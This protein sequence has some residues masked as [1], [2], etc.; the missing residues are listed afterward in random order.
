MLSLLENS[1]ILQEEIQLTEAQKEQIQTIHE[2]ANERRR[3]LFGGGQ[4]GGRGNRGGGQGGQN[5]GGRGNRGGGQNP[6]ALNS[7]GR[8]LGVQNPGGQN[9][10]G[11][12][13]GRGNRG[14]FGGGNFQAMRDQMNA[15]NEETEA[16]ILRILTKPQKTRLA[17]IALQ[18]E[19]P[20]AVTRPDIAASLKLTDS[21]IQKLQVA[22]TKMQ[23][24]QQEAMTAQMT[25]MRALFAAARTAGNPGGGPGGAPADQVAQNAGGRG[26]RNRF[27]MSPQMQEAMQTATKEAGELQDQTLAKTEAA[28]NKLLTASQK[29]KIKAM[30]G[31]EFD[32]VALATED[33]GRGGFGGFGGGRPGG[34]PATTTVPTGTRQ[35]GRSAAPATGR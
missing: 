27:S 34:P 13:G 9:P 17:Q 3:E 22:L 28:I 14:G 10:G 25:K 19:G 30:L 8:I 31:P 16:A 32:V 12:N 11:Q 20:L 21:Q 18:I 1:K 33:T 5:N 6:A 23:A 7:G 29:K 35:T 2:A 24:A 4:N 26:G 15:L